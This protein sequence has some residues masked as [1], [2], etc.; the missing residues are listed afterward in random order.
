MYYS[1]CGSE[2]HHDHHHYHPYRRNDRGCFLDE[3]KKEKPPTC[4][5]D[6]KKSE[7]AEAWILRMNKFFELHEYM[8][9]MKTIITIFNLKGKADIWWEDVKRVRDIRRNYFSWRDFKRLFRK[10]YLS[11]RYYDSK[12]KELYELKMG[13]MI[14]E[15]YTTKFLELLRYAPYLTYEKDKVQRVFSG[16][17]LAFRDQIE[18]NEPWLLEEVIGKLKHYY[19]KPKHKNESQN[20]W[21]GKDKGKGK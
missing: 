4:D 12:A 3:F 2:R 15:E 5:R 17:P 14:D 8:D 21:K 6:M 18:Y 7:D 19:E 11:E 9:N 20:G 1:S 13:S 10:K 16:F